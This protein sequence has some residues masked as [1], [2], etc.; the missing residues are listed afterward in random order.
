MK[1]FV[2][3]SEKTKLDKYNLS[4][5]N[6]TTD[7]NIAKILSKVGLTAES[8]EEGIA[9]LATTRKAYEIS[10]SRKKKCTAANR[11]FYKQKETLNKLYA[12]HRKIGKLVFE[13]DR[14]VYERLGLSAKYKRGYVDWLE[15]LKTFYN[16]VNADNSIKEKLVLLNITLEEIDT[17]IAA[18][19]PI[20]KA[21]ADY[22]LEKGVSQNSTSAKNMAFASM[23][24]WMDRFF[25]LAKVAFRKQ[26]QLMESFGIIVK[27]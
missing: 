10:N 25:E 7:A 8:L 4:L 14:N 27:N 12:K 24:D 22:M 9:L 11:E 3:L 13:E 26:P 1:R 6:A 18:I 5:T 20:E 2:K 23:D 15:L 17:A 21:R 16:K 19:A